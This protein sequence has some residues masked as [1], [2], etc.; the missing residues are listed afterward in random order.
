MAGMF[1]NLFGNNT[2]IVHNGGPGGHTPIAAAPAPANQQAAAPA[3]APVAPTEPSSP[4]DNHKTFWDNLKDA[5]GKEVVPAVDPTTTGVFNF[6]PA[7]I[8]ESA[9]NLNFTGN[10]CGSCRTD[11]SGSSKCSSSNDCSNR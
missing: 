6:D 3:Q 8:S 4:L 7:K 9:K 1:G 11:E 10:V 2:P 5:Q